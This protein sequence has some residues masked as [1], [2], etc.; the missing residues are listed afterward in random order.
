MALRSTYSIRKP[1]ASVYSSGSGSTSTF[2]SLAKKQA[3]AEDAIYDNKYEAGLI[4]AEDYLAKLEERAA[5][6]YTTPL[7][8]VNLQEK[9]I[10]VQQSVQ[11]AQVDRDY[12]AGKL[13]TAQVLSY[14]KSKLANM[15][16][17]GSEAY[18][19]QQQKIQQLTDKAEREAR[20]AARSQ[21]MLRISQM[22][23]DTSDR[24]LAKAQMYQRLSQQARLD[25]DTQTADNLAAQ[26]NIA[27]QGAKKAE[28]NDL[29]QNTRLSVSQTQ[30]PGIVADAA[31]GAQLFGKM[32]GGSV[33]PTSPAIKNALETLDRQQKTVERLYQQRA[34]AE[35]MIA[36]YR[37]A[38]GR[39]TGDQKTALTIQ[40]N[41]LVQGLTN[42]DA[43]IENTTAGINDTV[44]RIQEGQAKAAASG[45]SQEVRKA[46]SN[47]QK[48]ERDLEIEFSKGRIGKAEYLE[49]GAQLA[50]DKLG[51]YEQASD[52]FN[53]YGNDSRA[54]SYMTKANELSLVNDNLQQARANPDWYEPIAVEPGGKLTNLLG[55]G[56]KA[57]DVA[58]VDVRRLKDS[59]NFDSNY[60]NVDGVYRRVNY[61]GQQLDADGFPVSPGLSGDLAAMENNFYY[62]DTSGKKVPVKVAEVIDPNTKERKATFLTESQVQ[63]GL[64]D[65]MFIQ[66]DNRFVQVEPKKPGIFE[67]LFKGDP[68]KTIIP[69]GM[70][71]KDGI[72]KAGQ[73]I[74]QSK[75]LEMLQ[76]LFPV[77]NFGK[78]Q[79]KK[80]NEQ[81]FVQQAIDRGKG[82]FGEAGKLVSNAVS[83]LLG[84][85]TPKAYAAEPQK[86]TQY[87]DIID[88]VFGQDADK[89][90]RILAGEN[91][92]RLADFT[93]ENRINP[94]T[95]KYDSSAPVM[96]RK[97]PLT[98]KQVPSTDHGLA[99]I[100]NITYLDFLKRYPNEMKSIGFSGSGD[101]SELND[102][103]KNLMLA[104]L[105]GEKQG[106]AAWYAAPED[107]R[108][109]DP[110][111]TPNSSP[112][113]RQNYT[114]AP[115]PS[116]V[117]SP[118]PRQNYTPS[119]SP[120]A[121][122]MIY[123]QNMVLPKA[124][125]QPMQLPSLPKINIPQVS[126]P[127]INVPAPVQNVA[128]TVKNTVS[129]V[130]NTVKNT[131]S[132]AVSSVTNALK[133]LKFW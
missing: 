16:A 131:A 70:V 68:K 84:K 105:I 118:A 99:R 92:R 119:P 6:N 41:N 80:G 102:P 11:D 73:K 1:G 124:S 67:N 101:L 108:T 72:S 106:G 54:D 87:D 128:N 58:L 29:I 77:N 8:Q 98:G 37:E 111:S 46:E 75:G 50:A 76:N 28:I 19:Q 49:K 43:S 30:T 22:P 110:L 60:V 31:S 25:G 104:K 133:K 94:T 125:P 4:S 86:N 44:V 5:R 14:E 115:K 13:N 32:G 100:N 121:S 57:G 7:Q 27:L 120:S 39:A 88:E 59:G 17:P 103:R 89:F 130:A 74:Q 36:T 61:P 10:K 62:Y 42:I 83:N 9:M 81:S 26:A 85:I 112:A 113:P 127:K 114:P 109:R 96:M 82:F 129:N 55:G 116:P 3:A 90:R 65:K 53:Q 117:A 69:D 56:L 47:F 78:V 95:G 66:K 122:P 63:K 23:E 34:D 33:A 79:P 18:I 97:D 132:N 2:S 12:K 35:E 45:F 15:S 51:F 71:S 91:S 24:A 21:E 64:Q 52:G 40:L 48:A 126:L 123:G 20:T 38:V 107:M 93:T